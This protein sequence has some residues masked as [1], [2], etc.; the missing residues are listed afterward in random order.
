MHR[1]ASVDVPKAC[2]LKVPVNGGSAYRMD[3]TVQP[4]TTALAEWRANMLKAG[5]VLQKHG[6]VI[7]T[8]SV[9]SSRQCRSLD[10]TVDV[11]VDGT[12][13]SI[14]DGTVDG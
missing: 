11:I 10:G 7:D 2:P 14:V 8:E 6:K 5:G 4:N 1:P 12:V 9:R 13:D 3:P